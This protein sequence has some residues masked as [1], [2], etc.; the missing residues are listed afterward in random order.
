MVEFKDIPSVAWTELSNICPGFYNKCSI[1]LDYIEVQ[2]FSNVEGTPDSYDGE[3]KIYKD[4]TIE[5]D[6]DWDIPNLEI[7]SWGNKYNLW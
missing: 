2:V 5:T 3:F 4:G 7:W 1:H 6:T